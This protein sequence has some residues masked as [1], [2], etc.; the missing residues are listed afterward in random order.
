[1][2]DTSRE[3]R[4]HYLVEDRFLLVFAGTFGPS[5]GLDLVVKAAALISDI[6]DIQFLFLGDG[7]ERNRLEQQVKHLKLSNIRFG[8]FVSPEDYPYLLKEADAGIVSLSVKNKTPAVP[9]KT[10]GYMAAGL[11][12]IA[13]LN[14]ESDA[15]ELI[16]ESGCGVS[17]IAESEYVI[18]EAIRHFYAMKSRLA[19]MGLQGQRYVQ[20]NFDKK[21]CVGDI[22]ALIK[23]SN[24]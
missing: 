9:G 1:M 12:V 18:A 5:Q 19:D 2:A 13:F 24:A 4:K 11:P 14:K 17:V 6:S 8:S 20:A 23:P 15:H 22:E 10:I 21:K 7:L 16:R 3:F